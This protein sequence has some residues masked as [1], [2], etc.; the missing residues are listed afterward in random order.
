MDVDN[1]YGTREIQ[2]GLLVLMKE[3][4][5]FCARHKI[6]YSLAGGSLLGAIRHNG[7]IPWDDDLDVI[8]SREDYVK[9]L[10]L[11]KDGHEFV[12]S[13]SIWVYALHMKNAE[14]VNGNI[15]ALDI[16][17]IDNVPD[18]RCINII[19]LFMLM[20]LQGMI[21]KRRNY[22]NKSLFYRT[23]MVVTHF[24]G[25]LIPYK[26]K[27]QWYDRVSQIGNGKK[28][29][30][31]TCYNTTFNYLK[32][33][34]KPNLLHNLIRHEFD[35]QE[36]SITAEFDHYLKNQ[37]GDYMTPPEEKDRKPEHIIQ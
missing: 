22:K 2:K 16:F 14:L 21:K 37:Y 35:N 10:K 26:I 7:I 4:D 27:V 15:P 13:R 29:R 36:V 33:K 31:V 18:L 8:V 28:T 34:Y 6:K 25:L 24:W 12:L 32:L 30:Y 11:I 9:L 19:K 3:F 1:K 20:V 5:L 23:C 17:V